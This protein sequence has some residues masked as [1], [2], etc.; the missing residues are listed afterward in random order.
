[1]VMAPWILPVG[2]WGTAVIT[3]GSKGVPCHQDPNTCTFETNMLPRTVGPPPSPPCVP[4]AVFIP[5]PP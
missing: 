5:L 4:E 1:M 3:N 2:S